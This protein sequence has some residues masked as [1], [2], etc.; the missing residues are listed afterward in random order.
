MGQDLQYLY[1]LAGQ[2]VG[3]E[4]VRENVHRLTRYADRRFAH[5]EFTERYYFNVNRKVSGWKP[6]TLGKILALGLP[7]EPKERESQKAGPRSTRPVGEVP[8]IPFLEMVPDENDEFYFYDRSGFGYLAQL[9]TQVILAAMLDLAEREA[10]RLDAQKG[11]HVLDLTVLEL[12]TWDDG[13]MCLDD[14]EPVVRGMVSRGQDAAACEAAWQALSATAKKYT[15]GSER[16]SPTTKDDFR[17]VVEY[18]SHML[19]R[20]GY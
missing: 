15:I 11:V 7:E 5:S 16:R 1:R 12:E 20:E 19:W 10:A 17:G 2:F 8:R 13:A 4:K 18:T 9:A 3:S 14:L 6:E